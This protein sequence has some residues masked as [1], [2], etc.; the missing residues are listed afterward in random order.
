MAALLVT[1]TGVGLLLHPW[2]GAVA[3][4]APPSTSS[5]DAPVG[6]IEA[7]QRPSP[8]SFV[9]GELGRPP[10]LGRVQSRTPARGVPVALVVLVLAAGALSVGSPVGRRFLERSTRCGGTWWGLAAAERAPPLVAATAIPSR[11]A[12]SPA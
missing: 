9:A 2:A 12:A 1:L 8:A 6:E 11:P 3:V 5:A 4:G 10:V 7:S